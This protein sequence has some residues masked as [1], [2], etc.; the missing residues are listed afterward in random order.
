MADTLNEPE[1]SY[2]YVGD[3]SPDARRV[4]EF[5]VARVRMGQGQYGHLNLTEDK[6]D[7]AREEAEEIA[8]AYVY[9]SCGRLQRLLRGPR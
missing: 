9:H 1:G 7:F 5:I 8:D 6:R 2:V 4:V 3:L